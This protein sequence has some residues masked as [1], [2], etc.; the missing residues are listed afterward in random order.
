MRHV[1]GK[2]G[3]RG[4]HDAL[5][6]RRG[7][8]FSHSAGRRQAVEVSFGVDGELADSAISSRSRTAACRHPDWSFRTP[9]FSRCLDAGLRASEIGGERSG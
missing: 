1:E 3:G 6:R 9:R 5:G 7:A 4:E 8:S 2:L